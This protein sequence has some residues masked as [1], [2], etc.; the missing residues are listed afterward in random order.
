MLLGLRGEC[1]PQT[2]QTLLLFLFFSSPEQWWSL[3]PGPQSFIPTSAPTFWRQTALS[4]LTTLKSV[5]LVSTYFLFLDFIWMGFWN[6][7]L[8]GMMW[9]FHLNVSSC[10]THKTLRRS[11]GKIIRSSPETIA[12][13]LHPEH[14][15]AQLSILF[16]LSDYH[17]HL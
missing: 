4:T 5:C 1:L 15:S 9:L 8:Q 12:T 10:V 7:V 14:N 2:H 11:H 6:N 13:P 16:F 17:I 3:K